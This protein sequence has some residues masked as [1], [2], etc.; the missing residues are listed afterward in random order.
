[1]AKRTKI[2][3]GCF[4]D[5]K[6]NA[7]PILAIWL[8]LVTS[9]DAQVLL[10]PDDPQHAQT[11][12]GWAKGIGIQE[13]CLESALQT[14]AGQ[15]GGQCENAANLFK[16]TLLKGYCPAGCP[17]AQQLQA[18]VS[19]GPKGPF[20]ATSAVKERAPKGKVRQGK[21]GRSAR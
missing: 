10:D 1:M 21:A 7:Y 18:I 6:T 2:D 16:D 8:L 19:L 15:D 13:N 4:P 12:T 5:R 17:S 14:V 3:R 11:V 20:S 9:P